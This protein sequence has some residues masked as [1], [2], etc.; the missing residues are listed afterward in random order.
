MNQFNNALQQLHDATD[1]LDVPES[2]IARLSLPERVITV[3]VPVTM[4][5]GSVKIFIG[6]RS[7]H[8]S[9][10]GPYKGGIR[11]HQDVTEEE[12]KALSFWMSI[13]NAVINV[14]FGGGKG[15]VAVNPKELS[16]NELEKLSRVFARRIA[17]VIGPEID[18]PAPDVNTN[19]VIMGWMRDE[20]ERIVGHDAP[21]VITGKSVE[22]GGSLGR[23]EAT[24]RGGFFT[25]ER[26]REAFGFDPSDTTIAV[27]GFGNVGYHFARLAHEAGYRVVAVSDSRGGIVSDTSLNPSAVMEAKKSKGS[28]QN[29]EV[30]GARLITNE[31]LLELDV[32]VLVPSALENA[33][34]EENASKIRAKYI[35]EL[36]NGPVT[37]DADSALQNNGVT[38][39][40]DV[41]ANSGGVAVSYF[42]WKQ[43]M[44]DERWDED[45]VNAKLKKLMDAAFDEVYKLVKERSVTWRVASYQLALERIAEAMN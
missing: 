37:P 33:I 14:P 1:G 39:I 8:S 40:P 16:E 42:E 3:S 31:E 18:I 29:Y 22:N 17:P 20:Y 9:V 2:V 12:V 34:K 30:E 21:G 43:N 26:L 7:Q 5:D 41:L 45:V 32:D 36:A 19:G 24:G 13:K 44:L 35:L 6:F 15:G 38:V 23:T 27:Q 25:L 11:F 4:D 28:V 10:R